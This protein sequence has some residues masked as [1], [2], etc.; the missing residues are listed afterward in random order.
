MKG[1][2]VVQYAKITDIEGYKPT[3]VNLACLTTI[4]APAK[5]KVMQYKSDINMGDMDVA[6]NKEHQ[7]P[8]A[9]YFFTR[10]Q[11]NLLYE[12]EFVDD[13]NQMVVFCSADI[14]VTKAN[15]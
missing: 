5:S 11:D 8:K 15:K 12:P 9:D 7:I 3:P 4:G 1:K 2:V 14:K 13:I 6:E 10:S